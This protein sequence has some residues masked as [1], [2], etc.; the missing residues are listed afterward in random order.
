MSTWLFDL[1]NTRLKS[2]T[3]E[4]SGEPGA[5]R[6][7]AHGDDGG[8]LRDLPC[9]D[10]AC[11]ASVAGEAR[12]VALLDV[13]CTRFRRVHLVRTQ[14]RFAGLRIAYAEPRH[15]GVDRFLALLSALDAGDVLLVGVGTALTI[16]LLDAD[17]LHRGGRIA[18]SPW[19]MREALH[20]RAPVLPA[21]G[22]H[23]A[24]FADDTDH[25]LASGCEGAALALVERSLEQARSLLG[26]TPALW[27]HGGG[28][29]ALRDRLPPHQWRADAVLRGLARWQA[30]AMASTR[31]RA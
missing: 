9:G 7:V 28:A 11:I 12:R 8:W 24:E 29:Q 13:L 15:L 4:T 31:L 2:A 18:P 23:Y 17:G 19:L 14:A 6:A 3:L 10:V 5:V 16:D 1:G 21:S 30:H 22:G 27:L 25:A 26:A 20:A